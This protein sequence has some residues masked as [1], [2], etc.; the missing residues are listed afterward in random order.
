MNELFDKFTSL[1]VILP[2]DATIWL[3]QLCSSFLS[4]L[5]KDFSK[6]LT[7]ES[8]FIMPNLT[9]LTSKA[10]QLDSLRNICQ[11]AL[12]YYRNLANQKY[13]M[14]T[15]LRSLNSSQH[16]GLSL[17]INST[18]TQ[19]NNDSRCQSY[20]QQSPP[21]A[22]TT[23]SRYNDNNG[24]TVQSNKVTQDHIPSPDYNIHM[25]GYDIS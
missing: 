14:T 8:S 12:K 6:Q 18:K 11:H 4:A 22:K 3:I 25:T 1:S 24:G 16:R 10:K 7:T 20:Y 2:D 23:I 21:L 19:S 9:T 17:N 13:Q 5:T 15:L